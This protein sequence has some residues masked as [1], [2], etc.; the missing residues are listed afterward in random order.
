MLSVCAGLS[1]GEARLFCVLGL[2][3]GVCVLGSDLWRDTKSN[4]GVF[5]SVA[6]EAGSVWIGGRADFFLE[7][8]DFLPIFLS[9]EF[10][11]CGQLV[12][13]F[14]FRSKLIFSKKVD[15]APRYH[16]CAVKKTVTF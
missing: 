3:A 2:C 12:T 16:A 5:G 13:K 1:G 4:F 6:D 15:F 14:C 9:K 11:S 7:V 8:G 10:G